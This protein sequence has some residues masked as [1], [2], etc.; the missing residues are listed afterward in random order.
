MPISVRHWLPLA[1]ATVLACTPERSRDVDPIVTEDAGELD[2]GSGDGGLHSD[3]GPAHEDA[4]LDAGTSDAGPTDGGLDGGVA[5]AGCGLPRVTCGAD[6]A[7]LESDTNHCG[8]CENRCGDGQGCF[9]G[10]CGTSVCGTCAGGEYCE[11]ATRTCRT[12]CDSNSDCPQP[13]TCSGAHV[14]TCA[15]GSHA[16]GEACVS[17]QSTGSCGTSCSTCY[18]PWGG[19]ATCDGHSCGVSCGGGYHACGLDC[20]DNTSAQS[21]GQNCSPCGGPAS[22][23]YATCNSGQCGIACY[24]GFATCGGSCVQESPTQCGASCVSC[25]DPGV[26]HAT[27]DCLAGACTYQCTWP[28]LK[29]TNGCELAVAVYAGYYQTC[30]KTQS[31]AVPCWGGGSDSL[32]T[33]ATSISLGSTS[34]YLLSGQLKCGSSTISVSGVTFSQ[35]SVGDGHICAV[36][37]GNALYCWGSNTFGELGDGT[38]TYRSAPTLI[39]VGGSVQKVAAGGSHTCAILVGGSVKCWGYN[40]YGE[41]GNRDTS[42]FGADSSTPVAVSNLSGA[43]DITAGSEHT[44]AVAGG[45]LYCWGKNTWGELAQADGHCATVFSFNP[46]WDHC[47]APVAVTQLAS[48]VTAVATGNSNTCAVKDGVA[49]CWGYN[50]N[51]EIGTGAHGHY[52]VYTPAVVVASGAVG[53]STTVAGYFSCA[54]LSNGGVKCWGANSSGQ[55]GDG[56][57]TERDSPVQ[58]SAR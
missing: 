32:P 10:L 37:T 7:D 21:C 1:L 41:L 35:V 29:T 33:G 55:L 4:G 30:A 22:N 42:R 49:Y 8:T 51:G 58:A 12:G 2:A 50:D 16:C 46:Y 24:S 11:T 14:C 36:T 15:A 17:D 57:T 48:G 45:A 19:A 18:E 13:G 6:C 9:L 52:G 56:T 47:P 44:C 25:P 5:D 28:Y 39:N 43:T 23:G 34:C 31:G 38:T 20:F 27:A 26:A 54:V 3:A 40:Y 53:V